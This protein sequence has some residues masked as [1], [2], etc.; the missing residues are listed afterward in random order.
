M[1]CGLY[2]FLKDRSVEQHGC[3]IVFEDLLSKKKCLGIPPCNFLISLK[4]DFALE[5]RKQNLLESTMIVY[6]RL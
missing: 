3:I 4:D 6:Q 2:R 1:A 5:N